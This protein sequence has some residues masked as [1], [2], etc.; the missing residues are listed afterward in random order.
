VPILEGVSLVESLKAK[1]K[2]DAQGKRRR[3]FHYKVLLDIS[4]NHRGAVLINQFLT[5]ASE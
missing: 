1:N 3:S 4:I 5:G 2:F